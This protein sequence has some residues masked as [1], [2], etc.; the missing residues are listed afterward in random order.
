M[1]E[2]IEVPV[3]LLV[4]SASIHLLWTVGLV[5]VMLVTAIAPFQATTTMTVPPT[6]TATSV[7]EK[8]PVP[9]VAPFIPSPPT[10]CAD[11]NGEVGIDCPLMISGLSVTVK[12]LEWHASFT[13][14]DGQIWHTEV[15]TDQFLIIHL[16]LPLG[17]V[18]TDLNKWFL[19]DMGALAPIVVDGQGKIYPF[20]FAFVD[21][22]VTDRFAVSIIYVVARDAKGLL[23]NFPDGGATV[24]LSLVPVIASP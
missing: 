1:N 3:W 13:D 6:A 15:A 19:T 10:K 21:R 11:G 9:T 4:L 2:R 16:S 24:D 14:G 20:N 7:A 8:T 12:E 5:T 17:T 23:L 22:T 18:K